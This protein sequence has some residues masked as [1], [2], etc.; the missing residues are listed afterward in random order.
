[1]DGGAFIFAHLT[2]AA[3]VL[4]GTAMATKKKPLDW[5]LAPA[6]E[7]KDHVRIN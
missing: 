3:L 2:G 7:S 4:L 1:M 6:P 5:T